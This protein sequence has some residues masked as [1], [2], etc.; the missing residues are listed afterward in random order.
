MAK[1]IEDYF[2]SIKNKYALLVSPALEEIANES[3][4]KEHENMAVTLEPTSFLDGIIEATA[5][6]AVENIKLQEIEEAYAN[7]QKN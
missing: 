5:K 3:L 1:V 2:T 4:K 7:L 6:K